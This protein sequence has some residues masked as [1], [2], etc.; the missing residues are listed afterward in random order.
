[1]A[2]HNSV[3]VNPNEFHMGEFVQI[4][5]ELY[6]ILNTRMLDEHFAF[7]AAAIKWD[8]MTGRFTPRIVRMVL[9]GHKEYRVFGS[10]TRKSFGLS[11]KPL[12][13]KAWRRETTHYQ[14]DPQHNYL[15]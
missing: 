10:K 6:V 15:P 7:K 2:E 3:F 5:G 13:A 14:N 1:M 11:E 9:P 8:T 4:D 12:N